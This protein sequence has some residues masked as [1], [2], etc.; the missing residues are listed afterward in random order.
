MDMRD[1]F[2]LILPDEGYKFIVVNA[3]KHLSAES[4]DHMVDLVMAHDKGTNNV[5]HSCAA[6]HDPE[7]TDADGKVYWRKKDNARSAKSFWLDL[8]CGQKVDKHGELMYDDDGEPVWKDFKSQAEALTALK[9]FCTATALP[10]PMVVNS[11]TGWHCYWVLTESITAEQWLKIAEIF[12]GVLEAHNMPFDSSR[13]KDIASILR[14]VGSYHRKDP[15]NPKEVTCVREM[16]PVTPVAFLHTLLA[17]KVADRISGHKPEAGKPKPKLKS[18]AAFMGDS[19]YLNIPVHAPIIADKCAQ[20]GHFRETGSMSYANWWPAIGVLKYCVDGTKFI[21]EWGSKGAEYTHKETEFKISEWEKKPAFCETFGNFAKLCNNCD[22]KGKIKSP[23]SLGYAAA[24]EP[25]VVSDDT[26][27]DDDAEAKDASEIKALSIPKGFK[28]INDQLVLMKKDEDGDVV[29]IPVSN[30]AFAPYVRFPKDGVM[31]TGFK[32]RVRRDPTEASWQWKTFNIPSS[33]VGSG[34]NELMKELAAHEV[35]A[36]PGRKKYMEDYVA[37]SADDLRRRVAETNARAS[38]GWQPDGAFVI[39]KRCMTVDGESQLVLTGRNVASVIDAFPQPTGSLKGWTAAI[40]ELYDRPD[41][42][43]F[44]YVLYMGLGSILVNLWGSEVASNF[45]NLYGGKS[46]GKTS[47]IRAALSAYGNP[48][49]LLKV[50]KTGM[51]TNAIYTYLGTLNSIPM[52]ID[53][54]TNVQAAELSDFS[55]AIAGGKP[56][57]RL[58]HKG[59]LSKHGNEWKGTTFGSS[60]S[61]LMPKLA[62]HKDDA[63]AE[64]S[65]IIEFGWR[66]DINRATP[67]DARRLLTAISY[68]AGHAAPEMVRYVL[69]HKADVMRLLE[70]IRTKIDRHAGLSSD[71]RFWSAQHSCGITAGIIAKQ[72]GILPF[73]TAGVYKYMLGLIDQNRHAVEGMVSSAD[74]SFNTMVNALSGQIIRTHGEK[75][76]RVDSPDKVIV[77]GEPVGRMIRDRGELYIAITAIREYCHK[78]QIDYNTMRRSLQDT[79]ILLDAAKLYNIGKGTDCPTAPT[80][81]WKIDADAMRGEAREKVVHLAVAKG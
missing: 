65:R 75:D 17:A 12:R 8:D 55:Y 23:I 10:V 38:M 22:R 33:I 72:L 35:Y 46:T 6:Y 63:S 60:N 68:N 53:E 73:N 54:V 34:G 52:G 7:R 59:E 14:P 81:C 16:A 37:I 25:T 24:D 79:G 5:Y 69:D 2:A 20:I 80:R 27:D 43:Q 44:Q 36:L 51:T 66:K 47:A 42:E 11:G 19:D 21:H 57:E 58:T 15:K 4:F 9:K 64:M 49:V 40:G 48:E 1:F 71:Y 39:G 32:A 78:R 31:V 3:K 26:D 76:G 29:P 56:K 13:D 70:Q 45:V 30:V 28:V 77:H 41:H 18:N 61:P 62:G 67:E 74:N 50:F